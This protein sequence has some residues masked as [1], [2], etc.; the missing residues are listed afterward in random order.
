MI[1][2]NVVDVGFASQGTEGVQQFGAKLRENISFEYLGAMQMIV[3]CPSTLGGS[4]T[5]AVS[6]SLSAPSSSLSTDTCVSLILIDRN[7]PVLKENTFP[8]KTRLEEECFFTA[9]MPTKR[10]QISWAR[11]HSE[12]RD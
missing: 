3:P 10:W 11:H 2:H 7:S 4:I 1:C 9:E 12:V 6:Q 8:N 5:K